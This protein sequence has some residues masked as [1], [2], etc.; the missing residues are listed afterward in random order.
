MAGIE[1]AAHFWGYGLTLATLPI[2]PLFTPTKN[3]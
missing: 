2:V 3:I 1:P